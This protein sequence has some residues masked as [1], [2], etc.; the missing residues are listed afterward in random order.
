MADAVTTADAV[1]TDTG[2]RDDRWA[3]GHILALYSVRTLS[4]PFQARVGAVG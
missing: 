3:L 1:R 4:I 2:T